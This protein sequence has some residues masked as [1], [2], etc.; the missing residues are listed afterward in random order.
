VGTIV[1]LGCGSA[2]ELITITTMLLL[3][4]RPPPVSLKFC[5]LSSLNL[6]YNLIRSRNSWIFV[7]HIDFRFN[8]S[9]YIVVLSI[10]E[11]GV[12]ENIKVNAFFLQL[13]LISTYRFSLNRYFADFQ[14]KSADTTL[15]SGDV[16]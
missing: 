2:D 12:L 14:L 6:S 3:R 10:I 4:R 5:F 11:S 13:T 9:S 7:R 1:P 15:V 16:T 8:H